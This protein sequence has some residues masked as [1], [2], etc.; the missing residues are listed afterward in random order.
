M[1][2]AQ[3]A[4]SRLS[5]PATRHHAGKHGERVA[6]ETPSVVA[7]QLFADGVLHPLGRAA[8]DVAIHGEPARAMVLI[9]VRTGSTSKTLAGDVV[10]LTFEPAAGPS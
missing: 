6:I 7:V 8:V 5:F 4:T 10:S 3:T 9:E 1:K 2:I